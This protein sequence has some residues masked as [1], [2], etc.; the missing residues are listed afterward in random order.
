MKTSVDV[1]SLNVF[2]TSAK[3]CITLM[4]ASTEAFVEDTSI[5]AFTEDYGSSQI[6]FGG[7]YLGGSFHILHTFHE[8]LHGSF[9]KTSVDVT[10]T[11]ASITSARA[12][13]TSIKFSTGDFVDV[14]SIEAFGKTFVNDPVEDTSVEVS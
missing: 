8:S 4:K 3:K 14:T 9:H 1:S 10:P 6:T 5:K 7:S 11:K 2:I 12:P 13:F